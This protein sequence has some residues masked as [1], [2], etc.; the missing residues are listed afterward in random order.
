MMGCAV[1]STHCVLPTRQKDVLDWLNM[2]AL[3]RESLARSMRTLRTYRGS[4]SGLALGLEGPATGPLWA[5]FQEGK[6]MLL[7][8]SEASLGTMSVSGSELVW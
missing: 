3:R 1:G 4:L 8:S 2:L 7:A 5:S 6:V